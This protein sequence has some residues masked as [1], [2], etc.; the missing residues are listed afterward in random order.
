[1]LNDNKSYKVLTIDSINKVLVSEKNKGDKEDIM[2]LD[3]IE[4]L[5]SPF[6]TQVIFYMI[7]LGHRPKTL[8]E[9]FAT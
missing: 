1:M 8:Q 7:S 5:F 2:T 3:K 9:V 6:R 4:K